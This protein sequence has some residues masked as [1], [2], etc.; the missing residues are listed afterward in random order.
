MAVV[1]TKGGQWISGISGGT[2]YWYQRPEVLLVLAAVIITGIGDGGLA[3]G[4]ITGISGGDYYW[5]QRV[6]ILLVFALV[7]ITGISGRT[8]Y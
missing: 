6:E 4:N 3:G 1:V 2:S 7:I 5:Y 8:Y